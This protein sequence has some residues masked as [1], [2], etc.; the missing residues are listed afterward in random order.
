MSMGS[1]SSPW[2]QR[3]HGVAHGRHQGGVHARTFESRER[4]AL[5]ILE[6]TGCFYNR[7]AT[8]SA[9]GT[10]APGVRAGQLA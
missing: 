9:Q 8:H 2:G 10:S 7:V 5:E 4:A 1:I 3:G 6:C